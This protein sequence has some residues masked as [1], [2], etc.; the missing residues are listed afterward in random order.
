MPYIL[1]PVSLELDAR[2]QH[3]CMLHTTR[4]GYL[5]G[6][7]SFVNE[8]PVLKWQDLEYIRRQ[9]EAFSVMAFPHPIAALIIDLRDFKPWLGADAPLIPW[10]MMEEDCPV[11][12]LVSA[13]QRQHYS[14]VFEPAWLAW[15]LQASLKDMRDFFDMYLH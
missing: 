6:I 4:D 1:K 7:I 12:I 13:E 8:Y 11:R 3:E 10:R 15:D 5:I 9:G 14:A 2:T